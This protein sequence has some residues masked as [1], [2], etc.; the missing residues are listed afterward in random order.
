MPQRLKDFAKTVG[1][2]LI[3]LVL[4]ADGKPTVMKA[5]ARI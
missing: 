5:R 4:I 3:T 2:V 1:F